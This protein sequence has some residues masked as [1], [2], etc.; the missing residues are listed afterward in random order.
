MRFR[1]RRAAGNG[2]NKAAGATDT[3]QLEARPR[4][5]GRVGVM[6]PVV[7][8]LGAAA[9]WFGTP[10]QSPIALPGP[11]AAST[12]RPTST[13]APSVLGNTAG[14]GG[15]PTAS[16]GWPM[17]GHDAARTNFNPR[18]NILTQDNVA[19]L[20]SRWQV[21]IGIGSAPTSSAPSV[22]GGRIYVGSSA[23]DGPD[24]YSFD[25]SNGKLMWAASL[26]RSGT[27]FG[28]GIGATPAISG[29]VIVAGGNDA[30]YY[31]LDAASG[32]VLWRSSI[33]VGVSTFP[34]ASPLIAGDRAYVGIASGCDNPS[35]RGEVRAI[36]VTD[37]SLLASQ[38]FVPAGQA[39][40]GIWNS[41]ALTPDAKT[42]V[43]ATGEDY[44]GYNG[45]YNRAIVSLDPF[46][47]LIRTAN[48]QGPTDHD[49]DF[50]TTPI[51]FH[52]IRN[53]T[54]VAAHHKDEN[55]Y[56]YD[57]DDLPAGPI[58]QRQTGSIIGM[59]PAYDPTFAE[60]G[61]LFFLDGDGN[62]HAADPATGV[63]RWAPVAAGSARGNMALANGMVFLNTGP[64]GVEVF[65]EKDGHSLANLLPDRSGKAYSGVA[66]TGGF[67]YWLSG[68]YL[69]A[70]S[71][72][73]G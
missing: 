71:L 11:A 72:P 16:G 38:A 49:K 68:R 24:F 9:L 17:Y 22:S 70:W 63:D 23:V 52:D 27:C 39:G 1:A 13:S 46:S 18:E 19:Y 43:V 47:L 44:G 65:A 35:V 59:M 26:G 40:A 29:S 36:N 7:A 66:V 37:G 53:R 42:L 8:L 60:G 62:L 69:N 32:D 21:D 25:A 73:G 3:D 10:F 34:W 61:T 48:Q 51:I 20:V 56:A 54:L 45:P 58:W 57:L 55:F 30:A 31:G 12:P 41:P 6:V 5:L 67:V 15:A 28:V 33:D 14:S 4:R 50:A 2:R 64:G